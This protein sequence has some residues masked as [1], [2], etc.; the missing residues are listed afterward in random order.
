MLPPDLQRIE[1]IRDYCIA[2]KQTISRYGES[3]E[4]FDSDPDYQ[5][6]VSFSIF[7]IGELSGGLSKEY[8][9]Q[10]ASRIQWNPIRGMRNLVA[11]SYGSMDREVIWETAVT[12]IPILQQF[13]DEQLAGL[14]E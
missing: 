13:C 3:F 10:T 11:H 4:I 9:D 8:R 7:Q 14:D 5:R 12:D 6:S 2:I 1:H